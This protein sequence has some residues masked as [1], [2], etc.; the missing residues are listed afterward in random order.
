MA[1]RSVGAVAVDIVNRVEEIRP[2]LAGLG[3]EMQ[4]GILA[5]L[6]AMW[7]AG[8]MADRP[9]FREEILR[10]WLDAVRALIP[11]N[12]RIILERLEKH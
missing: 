12:E 4:G 9:D 10:H 7:L 2:L 1:E 8:H 5:D 6:V 11:V 3:S